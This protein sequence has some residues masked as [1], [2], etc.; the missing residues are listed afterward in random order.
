[1]LFVY[2]L[3]HQCS[4][5]TVSPAS[6]CSVHCELLLLCGDTMYISYVCCYCVSA[7]VHTVSVHFVWIPCVSTTLQATVFLYKIML[8]HYITALLIVCFLLL[9]LLFFLEGLDFRI[10]FLIIL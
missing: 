6:Y 8:L 3:L 9:L 7:R 4:F 2:A 10:I 5:I 1:M